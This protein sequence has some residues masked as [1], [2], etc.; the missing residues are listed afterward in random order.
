MVESRFAAMRAQG[1]RVS[2]HR[3]SAFGPF[4]GSLVLNDIPVLKQDSVFH[5][6]NI[7]RNPVDWQA[8][9]REAAVDDDEV[10]LRYDYSRLIPEGERDA[11]DQ[12]EETVA[13]RLN[14]RTVLNVV[15][16]PEALRCYIISLIE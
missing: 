1:E 14:V 12:V 15:G 2:K 9:A 16:R 10:S 7:R 3:V 5:A 4:L 6:D 11:L 13:A 8:E